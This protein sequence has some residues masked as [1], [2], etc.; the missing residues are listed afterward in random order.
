MLKIENLRFSYTK[1]ARFNFPDWEAMKGEHWLISGNSGCGKTT[2]LHL[3][4]GLLVPDSGKILINNTM[5][6]GLKPAEVDKFRGQNIGLIFQKHYFIGD[7]NMQQNLLSVQTLPGFTPDREHIS[8][9]MESLG[10]AN[11][12]HKKPADLSQGELQRFSVARAL[13]NKPKLL[14]ADEPTSSLDDQNCVTFLNLIRQNAERYRITLVI[15]THD[16]R[17]KG[18]FKNIYKL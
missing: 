14:L 5:L 6:N 13:V 2:L 9:M 8:E 15:A 18:H 4:A 7:I 11:L 17:L 1:N 16:A 12:R 3:L 10:I